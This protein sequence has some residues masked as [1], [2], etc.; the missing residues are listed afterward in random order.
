M[1]CVLYQV[2]GCL[3]YYDKVPDGFYMID[4]LDPYIWTLCIDLN[5][6]G[7]IPSIES[8]RA[9]DSGVDSSLEAILVDRRVDP[10]FKELH[11]RVHDISCSCITTKE[12]VDQLAKLICNRMGFVLI[13]SS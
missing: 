4:G 7:R 3:S 13:Q 6:S 9:I 5:E 11:N 12:V 2:N 8:L 10:A 1:F